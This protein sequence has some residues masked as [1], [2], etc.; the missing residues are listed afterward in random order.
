[1]TIKPQHKVFAI[2]VTFNGIEWLNRCLSSVRESTVNLKCIV[3]DN[4]STD[5]SQSFIKQNFPDV[6]LVETGENLGFGRANNH[7][8]GQAMALGA[9]YLLLLNQDAWIE[10]GTVAGMLQVMDNNPGY[11][12]VSPMHLNA[13]L[14]ALDVNF[15]KYIAPDKCPGLYSD[16]YTNNLKPVY[17]TGYINAAAWLVAA[18][19]I[20]KVGMFDPVFYHYGEDDNYCQR[21]IYHGFKIGVCP[22]QKIVHDRDD[23]TGIKEIP[24]RERWKRRMLIQLC[25]VN[26]ASLDK[27]I[28]SLQRGL[29]KSIVIGVLLLR[30]DQATESLAQYKFLNNNK[31]LILNSWQQNRVPYAV[32]F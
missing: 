10:P 4:N 26:Q 23:R 11:G 9:D 21:V 31:K 24:G 30:K 27:N 29:F 12:I 17:D 6:T 18:E 22:A 14:S 1:M 28:V 5:G 19:C 20:R 25:N 2:I 15:S 13:S 3:I 32:N 7:G 8:I 16:I